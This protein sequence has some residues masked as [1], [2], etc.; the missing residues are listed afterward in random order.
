MSLYR[1]YRPKTFEEMIGNE[2]QIKSLKKLLDK[3][4]DKPHTF[5][6]TG[7]A[8]TGKTTLARIC[9]NYL[10]ATEMNITEINTADNRGIDTAREIIEN[11]K[12]KP[13]LGKAKVYI[14]DEVHKTTPDWQN[15]MLKP[16]EDTPN[17]IYFFLCT[18][19]PEKLIKPLLSRTVTINLEPLSYENA[20]KLVK[21]VARQEGKVLDRD[22]VIEIASNCNQSHRT[23][24]VLLEKV[25]NIDNKEEA[26]KIIN[27]GFD[28]EDDKQV[29]DLCRILLNGKSWREVVKVLKGL[30]IKEPEE[31][32]YSVLGY[33]ASVLLNN[34]N[35]KVA[36]IILNFSESFYDS[37]FA[38]LTLACYNSFYFK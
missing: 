1:K 25:L 37:K 34:P 13:I 4:N 33:M 27:N 31:I 36:N 9:A 6:F 30:R 23:A 29:I 3:Q 15:A 35:D 38:G 2:E 16:L 24:L 5:L 11:M 20:I 12:Y 19:N 17:H 18:T 10:G 32:R 26:L 28:A 14:I 22:V 21:S 7:F 8:G